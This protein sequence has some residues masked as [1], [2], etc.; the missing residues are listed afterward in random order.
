MIERLLRE[1]LAEARKNKELRAR[2]LDAAG[3]PD[4][5][6]EFCAVCRSEGYELYPGDIL[7]YGQD[8]NDSKLRATNGGGSFAIDGWD[9]AFE[10]II[11]ELKG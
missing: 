9:D 1:L 7:A 10:N 8:M 11:D 5:V 6:K 3:K 2:L 4:A